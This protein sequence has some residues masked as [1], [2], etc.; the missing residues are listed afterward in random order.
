MKNL[1]IMG[2][3]FIGSLLLMGCGNQ[4]EDPEEVTLSFLKENFV[5]RNFE[6]AQKYTDVK[7]E[8]NI[9]EAK[10]INNE[11]RKNNMNK[12]TVFYSEKDST[13]DKKEY[14]VFIPEF[15]ESIDF[16][17]EQESG[18]WKITDYKTKIFMDPEETVDFVNSKD[19]EE[20]FIY[21][22]EKE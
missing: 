11:L 17:L 20:K 5:L 12:L 10:K 2:F 6:E 8:T 14:Q 19:W 13:N 4:F 9:N 1:I 21:G 7:K 18:E 16:T 22:K 3:L 15:T